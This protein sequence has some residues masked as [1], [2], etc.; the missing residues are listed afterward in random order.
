VYFPKMFVQLRPFVPSSRK[1]SITTSVSSTSTLHIGRPLIAPST[2]RPPREIEDLTQSDARRRNRGQ[3]SERN[4]FQSLNSND[5]TSRPPPTSPIA[6][7]HNQSQSQQT[8][9]TKQ[10]KTWSTLSSSTST[11]R[12]TSSPS[13]SSSPSFK[14][15]ARYT[16][17][18]RRLLVGEYLINYL[19]NHAAARHRANLKPRFVMQD[20]KDPRAFTI[21]E[22]YENEGSQ[23]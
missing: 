1:Q 16:A 20:H 17:T 11:P 9:P 2:I 3:T 7:K 18:T 6:T 22:R 4:S 10:P 8:K 19:N 13:T 12:R 23:K 5:I 15:R 14:R 21:V